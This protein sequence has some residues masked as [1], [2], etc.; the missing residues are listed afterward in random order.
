LSIK[1]NIK[2]KTQSLDQRA[3]QML[4]LSTRSRKHVHQQSSSPNEKNQVLRLRS[5][6]LSSFI[7]ID[8]GKKE[9]KIRNSRSGCHTLLNIGASVPVTIR[10]SAL[11]HL[12][13]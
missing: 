11:R 4:Q 7:V 2:S 6:V 9:R 1:E 8:V 5:I 13:S 3:W 10:D 12:H